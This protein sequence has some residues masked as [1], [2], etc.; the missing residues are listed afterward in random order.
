MTFVA[1]SANKQ[2]VTEFG[3]PFVMK[4]H[5]LPLF[6]E[7]KRG[8]TDLTEDLREGR[9]STATTD[10]N[11]SALR[12]M[13]ETDRRV[14]YQQRIQL[15]FGDDAPRSSL[16]S[17]FNEFRRGRDRLLDDLREGRSATAV[18][19]TDIDIGR[20]I[21]L[22]SSEPAANSFQGA[23]E[24]VPKENRANYFLQRLQRM[25]KYQTRVDGLAARLRFAAS[26]STINYNA[27]PQT[28]FGTRTC[29][30]RIPSS[31]SSPRAAPP[32]PNTCGHFFFFTAPDFNE[33]PTHREGRYVPRDES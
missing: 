4:F 19:E 21:R 28:R 6:N 18:A 30:F 24:D 29:A 20:G 13:I 1:I 2:I 3:R 12:L 22:T 16:Y 17:F 8:R 7:F 9:P 15:A 14:T 10:D 31:G 5:L 33:E 23:I 32:P 11:V 25:H 26:S 27:S